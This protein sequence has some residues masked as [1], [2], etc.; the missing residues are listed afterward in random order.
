M[1]VF[2]QTKAGYRTH[3]LQKSLSVVLHF[4]IFHVH[5]MGLWCEEAFPCDKHLCT[6]VWLKL[7]L[8]SELFIVNN[9]P[10]ACNESILMMQWLTKLH[11]VRMVP[12]T[13]LS[14]RVRLTGFVAYMV[15]AV[16][17]AQLTPSLPVRH[18]PLLAH[19]T[20]LHCSLH[21][22]ANTQTLTVDM[23]VGAMGNGYVVSLCKKTAVHSSVVQCDWLKWDGATEL[24]RLPSGINK[25]VFCHV[26]GCFWLTHSRIDFVFIPSDICLSLA[27][28]GVTTAIQLG[29]VTKLYHQKGPVILQAHLKLANHCERS[30]NYITLLHIHI[31]FNSRPIWDC[32]INQILAKYVFTI[33]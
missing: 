13:Q 1:C 25:I 2:F 15:L 26:Y 16:L 9:W 29:F 22:T 27:G 10:T 18:T 23:Q 28:I 32:K 12:P 30:N 4:H 3:N 24:A 20:D 11:Y 5:L 6:L 17:G 8:I 33:V 19:E 31:L 21:I 14:C 7:N